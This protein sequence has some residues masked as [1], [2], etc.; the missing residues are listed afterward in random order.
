MY[1]DIIIEYR[2]LA[3]FLFNRF[4]YYIQNMWRILIVFVLLV[5]RYVYSSFLQLKRVSW[6]KRHIRLP[7]GNCDFDRMTLEK[8]YALYTSRFTNTGK[9]SHVLQIPEFVYVFFDVLACTCTMYLRSQTDL[10]LDIF[11]KTSISQH[12]VS[13]KNDWSSAHI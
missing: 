1:N 2:P 7:Y 3:F 6:L 5:S 13:V 8:R 10:L 11:I 4:R 12:M 9:M